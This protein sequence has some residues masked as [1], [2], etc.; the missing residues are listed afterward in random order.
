MKT[1]I[2]IWWLLITAIIVSA[3]FKQ[4]KSEPKTTVKTKEVIK[5]KT[6]TITNVVIKEVPKI[7]NVNKYIDK[8]GEKVIVYVDKRNDS[9]ITANQYQ[10]EIKSDS[11]TAKL[12]IT[13]TGELLDIQGVITYPRIEKTTTITNTVDASG[14][15]MY[16]K[17]DVLDNFKSVDAGVFLHLNNK[18]G[19]LLEVGY[20]DRIKQVSNNG[21]NSSLGIAIKF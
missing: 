15:F 17:T 8:Q 5:W 9:T 4:C 3:L 12:S 6:D 1:K 19:L 14:R 13:T 7:V 10:T 20:D 21:F 18:L 11:A 2:S 16:L